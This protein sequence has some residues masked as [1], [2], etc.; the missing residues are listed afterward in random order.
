MCL[1]LLP[2]AIAWA[3]GGAAIGGVVTDDTQSAL[4]GVTV[5]LTNANTGATQA[6]VTG[7][8]GN[9]RAVNLPPGPYTLVAELAGFAEYRR[10]LTL[11]VG[12]NTTINI[13][14]TVA[15]PE[16]EHHRDAARARWSRCPRPSH[17]R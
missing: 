7:P 14:M 11:L 13:T 17:R 4:P 10:S 15:T 2:S 9:Y 1:V 3:Q 6:I 8:E 16:R 12:A 5:T